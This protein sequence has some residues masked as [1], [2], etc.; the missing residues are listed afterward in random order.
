MNQFSNSTL[1]I[2][3]RA[4][5]VKHTLISAPARGPVA[6]LPDRRP[7]WKQFFFSMGSQ[8]ALVVLLLWLSLLRPHVLAPP[9]RDYHNVVLVS[10]P[11]AVNHDPAPIKPL[12][13]PAAVEV[14]VPDALRVPSPA[15]IQRADAPVAP[16]IEVKDKLPVQP[17]TAV[18]PKAAVKTNVFSTGSS[19]APTIEK[20]VQAVQTGGFGDPH[21]VPAQDNK[22][23]PVTIAQQG[24]FDLPSGAGYGNGTGG[25][26]GVPGVV[27][28]TGFGDGTA[29][30]DLHGNGNRV[31][32][33][34][35]FGDAQTADLKNVSKHTDAAPRIKPAEIISKPTPSYTEEARKLRIEG[36]VLLEVKFEASGSIQVMR[37]I[38]GLGHGLDESAIKA[39]QQI[40]FNPAQKDGQPVDFTGVLHITFQLA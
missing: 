10:T 28:S 2:A 39:A 31:V 24:A 12:R 1:E 34:G 14:K 22:N 27:A 36:E 19:Q 16:K 8:G 29:T 26:K 13:T 6:M 4:E 35:A 18:I 15:K 7:P 17:V 37:V 5:A 9:L 32:Q 3:D 40:R 38:R 23:R 21:G 20:P 25:A 11:H 33:Q 30:S